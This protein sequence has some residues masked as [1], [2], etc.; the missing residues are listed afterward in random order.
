M[1]LLGG[2]LFH[3]NKPSRLTLYKAVSLLRTYCFGDDPIQFQI[4]S[5]QTRN[6][7]SS[8]VILAFYAPLRAVLIAFVRMVCSV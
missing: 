1:V 3:D 6:F 2:D 7:P 5:D 8:Y 4:V